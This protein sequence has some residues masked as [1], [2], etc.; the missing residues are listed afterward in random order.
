MPSSSSRTVPLIVAC[1]LFME[2]LDATVISTAL[3]AIAKD[4]GEDPLHLSLAITSYLLSL[5][6]F[7][8]LSGW[9][10]DRYG[11]R[12]VF[13]N[14]ILIFVLGSVACAAADDVG[15]LVAARML[16][17][18][19]GALMV[20]VGRLVLLRQ[21]PKAELIAAMSFVT[22][23]A[24]T[25]PIFG[26]PL[27]GLIVTY[28]SWEWI[29]LINVPIGV[30]GWILVTRYIRDT[31][32]ELRA[33]L[34]LA[35]WWVLGGAMAGLVFGLESLGKHVVS[36][37]ATYLSLSIGVLL[38]ML[39][40]RHARTDDAPILRLSLLRLQSFRASV[41]GGSLFR[42]GLGGSTLLLPMMLQLGYGLSPL[43]SGLL[44]FATA[45]GALSMKIVAPG[46]T[47]RF[48]FRSILVYNTAI[49][50]LGL[51]VC[52]WLS[53]TWPV[54][55][56]LAVLLLTGF[57]RSLQFTCINALAFAD[58][59]NPDMSQAT[60][61]SSTAQQLALS[62]GVGLSSQV[63]NVSMALR[64][65]TA[66]SITDFTNAFCFMALVSLSAIFAFRQLGADAGNVVSGH[67]LV[68]AH[69]SSA[70]DVD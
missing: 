64:G 62:V 35:G 65:A 67:R 3:P 11:A 2:N 70:K 18:L 58:V 39:Y 13:R 60:S 69:G 45:V 51:M 53:P 41:T 68:L 50:A 22:V 14:A 27:G 21:V 32:E 43:H 5:S 10:A 15:G 44:T 29:F 23:P 36:P 59:P 66:L 8:P 34:D 20:P 7:I 42:I 17:G 47:R 46:I 12:A 61:F 63:L 31:R 28:S 48:G 38:L 54:G 49:C 37:G 1:A 30:L 19:G 9:L 25:A 33:P 55:I 56:A 16:Q 40:V 6:I 57:F 26:P 52:G 4:L 24:L